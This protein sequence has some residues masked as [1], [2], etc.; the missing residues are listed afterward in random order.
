VYA[1]GGVVVADGWTFRAAG[2]G[3]GLPRRSSGG[4]DLPANL[5]E[6]LE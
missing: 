2:S 1:D 4:G 5:A 3:T 6:L